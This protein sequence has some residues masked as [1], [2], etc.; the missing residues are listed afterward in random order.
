MQK[1]KRISKKIGKAIGVILVVLLILAVGFKIY[2]NGFY[3]ADLD[4]IAEIEQSVSENVQT[5]KGK[6]VLVFAPLNENPKAIIVFYPGGKVEYTA[7]SGLMYELAYRGYTCVLPR[8]PENLAFLRIET[9]DD[10]KSEYP[11]EVEKFQDVDWYLAGHSL[12]GVAATSYLASQPEG[13][14]KGIILCASYTTSDFSSSNLRL[15]S[16]FASEDGV[17]NTASYEDSKKMWPADSKEY[18]IEGGIHS[19]FGNY[20]IQKGDGTPSI[21]NIEQI[22]EAADVIAEFISCS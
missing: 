16:L 4:A 6:D 22:N 12:G 10:I 1:V 19:Y 13:M 9:I 17:I 21:T 14:Y 2:S 11:F 7:Y 5:F 20:G 15:L 8:M 18:V 3:R